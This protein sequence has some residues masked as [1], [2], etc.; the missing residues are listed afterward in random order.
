MPVKV[1]FER[2]GYTVVEGYTVTVTVTLSK[3]PERQVVIPIT[4]TEE[5]GLTSADYSG[6]PDTV[7][8]NSGDT[9]S[10]FTFT[11]TQERA[12]GR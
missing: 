7:I 4:K 10:T 9:S 1:S 6:V 11:A 12:A 5:G 2:T 3:D 8:F